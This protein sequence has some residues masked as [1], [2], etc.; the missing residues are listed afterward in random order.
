MVRSYFIVLIAVITAGQTGA[1]PGA[2]DT[3]K[4]SHRRHVTEAGVAC[5]DCH[6]TINESTARKPAGLPNKEICEGCHEETRDQDKCGFCHTNV[7]QAEALKITLQFKGFS[8]QNH[9]QKQPECLFCHTGAD[10]AEKLQSA[11]KPPMEKC[12]A[13]HND[14]KAPAGCRTCHEDPSRLKPA[15][16]QG[17]WLY[18]E[19]HGLEA[20]LDKAIC[21]QCHQD[22]FCEDCHT[23][24]RSNRIHDF[25]Y[26]YTHGLDAKTR[27][28][29]C[30]LCHEAVHQCRTCH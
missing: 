6:G 18:Q 29:N 22:S 21:E 17:R 24:A 30:A 8:H 11:G 3:L 12:L 15:T 19:G 14:K 26:R 27:D 7:D 10:Q 28:K 23:G 1:G 13:C 16:H 20:R 2:R 9:L 5:L 4:F 25:N